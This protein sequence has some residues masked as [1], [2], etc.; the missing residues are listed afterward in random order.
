METQIKN[1]SILI[2]PE[3]HQKVKV[4]AD[5]FKVSVKQLVEDMINYSHKTGFNPTVM[6]RDRV[7]EKLN[8]IQKT[9]ENNG[10]SNDENK[11][12]KYSQALISIQSDMSKFFKHM[13]IS[14][15]TKMQ[16]LESK[17][18]EYFEFI[19]T[20]YASQYKLYKNVNNEYP[21]ILNGVAPGQS[22]EFTSSL[23]DFVKSTKE[24]INI[25]NKLFPSKKS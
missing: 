7:M 1:K 22:R 20:L 14:I 15:N 19:R 23:I 10:N 12:E 24:I 3:Q 16:D 4:L 21:N 17:K 6:T 11:I 13:D 25:K 9:V 5:Q 18:S 8:Q 2:D